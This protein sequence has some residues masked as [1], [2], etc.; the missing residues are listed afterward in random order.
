MGN[1]SLQGRGDQVSKD[2]PQGRG[3][4]ISRGLR[5]GLPRTSEMIGVGSHTQWVS[6]RVLGRVLHCA[7][8]Y[9]EDSLRVGGF[10]S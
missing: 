4:V 10:R 5:C 9:P 2:L 1:V 8:L 3:Q 7:G 6:P